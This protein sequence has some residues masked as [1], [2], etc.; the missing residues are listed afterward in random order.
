MGVGVLLLNAMCRG[1]LSVTSKMT[2]LHMGRLVLL[3]AECM[4]DYTCDLSTK[5]KVQMECLN[6]HTTNALEDICA[7]ETARPAGYGASETPCLETGLGGAA[8]SDAAP[9]SK[10]PDVF[11]L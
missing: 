1:W 2:I 6:K 5:D 3:L 8:D 4:G 11:H 7:L 9:P 10:F